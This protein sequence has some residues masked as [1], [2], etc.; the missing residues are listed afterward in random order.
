MMAA[1]HIIRA[2]KQAVLPSDVAAFWQDHI[3]PM[4]SAESRGR[5]LAITPASDQAVTLTIEPNRAFKGF[6]AGQHVT[7][8]AR[9]N[10]AWVARSYSPRYL[11]GSI[12]GAFKITVQRVTN[13]RFSQWAHDKAR[14]GDWLKLSDAYGELRLPAGNAPVLM[15]AAGSGITPFLSLLQS[16]PLQRPTQLHY[17]VKARENACHLDELQALQTREQNF[18][19]TLH[20]TEG[21]RA[22]TRLNTQHVT[23]CLIGTEL[24]ACGPA[25]FI[26]TA[27]ALASTH[28]LALQSEA[29]TLPLVVSD[30]TQLVNI[31]LARSGKVVQVASGAALLP[32]LEA[33]GV[34]L[35]SGCRRGI[36][37]TC[38]CGKSKGVSENIITQLR[39]DGDT[40]GLRLCISSARS[41][42]VLD[43]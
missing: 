30:A 37:N 13:G 9:V 10:G 16:A 4:H 6:T 18:Q 27:N 2:L 21:D 3:A 38:A 40:P 36:C 26:A 41:D 42:L 23:D 39:D 31:T 29:F 15:L 17:W 28:G 14:L 8:S 25:G 34:S 11:A 19:L 24:M 5:L 32:A 12:N 22:A 7:V 20:I 33:Q 35:A 1:Q 43:I